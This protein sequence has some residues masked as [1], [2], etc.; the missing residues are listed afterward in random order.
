MERGVWENYLPILTLCLVICVSWCDG[1]ICDISE[2][3][4]PLKEE[5]N[6]K[7]TVTKF[8]NKE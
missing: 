5:F 1:K 6:I 4:T 3:I 8:T 2:K 7:K